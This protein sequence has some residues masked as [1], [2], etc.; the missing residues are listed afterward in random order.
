[1]NS[2][3]NGYCSSGQPPKIHFGNGTYTINSGILIAATQNT[4]GGLWLDGSGSSNTVLTT[5]CSGNSYGIWYN[6][7]SVTGGDNLNGIRISNMMVWSTGGFACQD[8]IRL[9]Q[10]ARNVIENVVL[11]GFSGGN[12][13]TGTISTSGSTVS[14]VGTTFTPA[15]AHG[16]LE[17][18]TGGTTRRGEVCAYNSATSLTL[19]GTTFPGGNL[20]AGTSFAVPYGGRGIT[21]D[22]GNSYSQYISIRNVY[23]SNS[24]F[25]FFGMG[26]G[27]TS[28]GCSRVSI[29]GKANYFA[30]NPGSRLTDSVGVWMGKGSD[31]LFFN[32][33]IN[34]V[35]LC[36]GF[37]TSHANTVSGDCENSVS[38]TGPTPV[39][40]CNG[41]TALQSCLIGVEASS[42]TNGRGYANDFSNAYIY[43][44]GNVFQF[45]N[46]TG[47]YQAKI[48][49][50]RTL[51]G[52]AYTNHFYFYGTAGCPGN[53]SGIPVIIHTFD[54]N[55]EL[56][57]QSV[58]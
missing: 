29:E 37:E 44:V 46:S 19:C 35:S 40:T 54:C 50:D 16:L 49:G 26:V 20:A 33:A 9:T 2:N 42:D 39:T 48:F 7:T 14:G 11:A 43:N 36:W 22:P 47:A 23:S 53:G 55:H 4:C 6:N 32:A 18:T 31:T 25:G 30:S 10:T 41:G 57:S 13:S 28:G 52:A 17:V 24:L 58:N 27:G 51:S 21:C 45:D 15:M 34:N 3:I 12:Y 8:G 56:V 38:G 5:N 1:L